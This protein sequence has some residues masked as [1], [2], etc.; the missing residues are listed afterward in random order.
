M[1][2][3]EVIALLYTL[4]D[5][6]IAT[7]YN[8]NANDVSYYLGLKDGIEG[9]RRHMLYYLEHYCE[10]IATNADHFRSM[11]DEQLAEKIDNSN[12]CPVPIEFTD[13][14]FCEANSD[15]KSCILNWLKQPYIKEDF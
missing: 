4:S 7:N 14:K 9:F 15:C 1:N 10:N 2:K 6:Y 8:K 11:T 12:Y 5:E 3:E 13:N